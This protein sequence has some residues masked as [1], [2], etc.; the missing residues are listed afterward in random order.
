MARTFQRLAILIAITGT[1]IAYLSRMPNSD[2]IE[3]INRVRSLAAML[4]LT[5]LLVC[6]PP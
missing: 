1:F 5:H 2:G 3:Q 6:H 4:K